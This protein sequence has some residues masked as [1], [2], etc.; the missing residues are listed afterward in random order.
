MILALYKGTR[1]GLSGLFNRLVRWWCRGPYSHCEIIFSDGLSGS[2][3]FLDGGVRLKKIDYSPDRW[4]FF[5]VST[6]EKSA[7][8][9]FDRHLSK[10][11]DVRGIFGCVIRSV[12]DDKDKYFCSEA[13]MAALGYSEAWRFD[14][15]LM[16]NIFNQTKTELKK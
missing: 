7:R 6:D 5:S 10:R 14:P 8:D 13:I 9:W 11:Y 15:C 4:D 1:P 3:S 12:S 16:S 2:S